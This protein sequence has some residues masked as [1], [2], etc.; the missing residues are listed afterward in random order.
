[1]KQLVI[2]SL[3]ILVGI[4][5]MTSQSA[6]AK[7]ET[8]I[9]A[10]GCFWCMEPPYDKLDGVIRT[11]SG[12]TGG[13]VESPTYQQVS[14]GTTGHVEAIEIEFDPSKVS[15][16]KLLEVYWHNINPLQA[17]GQF[18]DH[19]E[20]YRSVIFY[21]DEAQEQAAQ[22][23]LQALKD[24]GKFAKSIKTEI[25]PAS[26][27]YPAEEYHQDYYKKNPIRYKYYRYRCGRDKTLQ[28]LWGNR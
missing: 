10:G 21:R 22:A 25:L 17:N 2:T 16:D 18:C 8:A 19:G 1:M 9:F 26:V 7:T 11:T 23:S 12:Y 27:F 4:L 24:S 28:E 20:Q 13:H 3:S 15:Y 14:S 5:L 6:N